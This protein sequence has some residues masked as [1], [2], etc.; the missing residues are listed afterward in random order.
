MRGNPLH[1]SSRA[2]IKIS[3]LTFESGDITGG[4]RLEPKNVTRLV[5]RLRQEGCLRRDPQRYIAAIISRDVL[6]SALHRSNRELVDLEAPGE[7]H[8]LDL[9]KDTLQCLHGK[10]RIEAA[11]QCLDPFDDWWIINLYAPGK[12][13]TSL[14]RLLIP[15]IKV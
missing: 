4:R 1:T 11:K 6:L 9:G 8:F 2:K 7:P 3:G 14:T 12:P 5:K 13:S 15:H 10:H